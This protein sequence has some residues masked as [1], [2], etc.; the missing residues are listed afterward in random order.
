MLVLR[1]G[2]WYVR[3]N[4]PKEEVDDCVLCDWEPW[5]V[6]NKS[7]GTEGLK[8]WVKEA[9]LQEVYK[10]HASVLIKLAMQCTFLVSRQP[11]M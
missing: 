5:L 3:I 9:R 8:R 6:D 7:A 10:A 2:L 11:Q 1:A 4:K